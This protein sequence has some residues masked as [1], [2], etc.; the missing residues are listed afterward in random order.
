VAK[1]VTNINGKTWKTVSAGS[2]WS[3][4][5]TWKGLVVALVIVGCFLTAHLMG[6]IDNDYYDYGS[7]YKIEET[8]R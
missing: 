6:W 3:D 5:N 4:P 2:D 7:K 8:E 1:G